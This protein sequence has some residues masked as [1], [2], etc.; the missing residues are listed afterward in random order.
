[1]TVYGG[2]WKLNTGDP[3]PASIFPPDPWGGSNGQMPEEEL[4]S[5]LQRILTDSAVFCDSELSQSRAEAT[6]YWLGKPFGNEEEGRS[7]VIETVLRDCVVAIKPALME[8]AFGNE[9][10]VEYVPDRP[11]NVA[12]AEQAT[13][14]AQWVFAED[15]PG[16]RIV[17]SVLTDAFVRKIGVVKAWWDRSETIESYTFEHL[18]DDEIAV[19]AGDPD[20]TITSQTPIG[21]APPPEA[22]PPPSPPPGPPGG[23]PTAPPQP[24]API[25]MMYRVEATRKTNDGRLAIMALPPEEFLF[26][27]EAR[28]LHDALLIAH[29]RNITRG[30]GLALGISPEDLD[31]YGGDDAILRYNEEE[32]ARREVIDAGVY[33]TPDMG[34]ANQKVLY[35]EAYV[36]VDYDGDGVSELRR[37]CCLGPNYHV[38]SNDPAAYRPFAYW[39]PLPEPHVMVGQSFYDILAPLQLSIS[40]MRRAMNDSAAASINPRIGY[41]AGQVSTQDVLNT[42]I[43]APIRMAAPGMVQPITVPFMGEMMM[44][45]IENMYEVVERRTGIS[46]GA[47]GIDADALQSTE[48]NAAQAAVQGSQ[49]QQKMY[50]RTF[51]EDFLKPL[52]KI[53]RK[54][55]AEEQPRARVM[56]LRGQWVTVDPRVWDTDMDVTVNVGLGYADTAKKMAALTQVYTEQKDIIS[57]LGMA[58]PVVPVGK[59]L[60]TVDDFMKLAGFKDYTRYFNDLP[61]NWTPPPAPQPPNPAL[62]ALQIEQQKVMA[63][64]QLKQAELQLK[65]QEA[66]AKQDLELKKLSADFTLRRYQI[67]SQFKANYTEQ[68]FTA[69]STTGEMWL[70]A[71]DQAT[72]QTLAARGQQHAQML[73]QQQQAHEQALAAQ[74]QQHAQAMAEQQAAQQAQQPQAPQPSTGDA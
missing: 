64:L 44:P 10:A 37:V 60:N 72:Q 39:T 24:P 73:A 28:N 46:R 4:Q 23:A 70:K 14:Y 31:Q 32:V 58:N 49:Q 54:I 68:Q 20:V 33:R 43:G 22:P 21:P 40:A 56:R 63:E 53:I 69:D 67:D 11:E 26:D 74:Q 48:A 25:Q 59:L 57:Q 61:E 1:M 16:F 18:T 7:Q 19:L 66:A 41:V 45:M 12:A 50:A 62:L 6:L 5:L 36:K 42:E 71:Q 47:L 3:Q 52:F 65:Q 30:E 13:D 34:E 55:L 38:I 2:G 35:V 27:R 15:N 9:R 29:R 51:A 8:I 17:D